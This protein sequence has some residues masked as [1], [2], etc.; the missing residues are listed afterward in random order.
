MFYDTT[1]IQNK[2]LETYGTCKAYC[3]KSGIKPSTLSR[4]L[5]T[6]RWN[7]SEID[8]LIRTLGIPDKDINLYF[9][10]QRVPKKEL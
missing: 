1:L 5:N 8:T 9:F 7:S 3:S 6:G 4:K 2:I 10:V